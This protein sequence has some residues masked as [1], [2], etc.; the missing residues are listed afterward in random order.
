ASAVRGRKKARVP[1]PQSPDRGPGHTPAPAA[2]ALAGRLLAPSSLTLVPCMGADLRSRQGLRYPMSSARPTWPDRQL[3]ARECVGTDSPMAS[4]Q[5]WQSASLEALVPP[6]DGGPEAL[7]ARDLA[8]LLALGRLCHRG[9]AEHL[10]TVL[11]ARR[12]PA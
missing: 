9:E 11:E 8:E 7:L 6:A 1:P 2:P 4:R 12:Q 3:V 10:L 5:G